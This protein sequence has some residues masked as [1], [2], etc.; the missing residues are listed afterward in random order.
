MEPQLNITENSTNLL[1]KILGKNVTILRNEAN[2]AIQSDYELEAKFEWFNRIKSNFTDKLRSLWNLAET[3]YSV[4]TEIKEFAN[5]ISNLWTT[6]NQQVCKQYSKIQIMSHTLPGIPLS[7]LLDKIRKEAVMVKMKLQ[8]NEV[9]YDFTDILR[10]YKLFSEIAEL[11][12][13]LERYDNKVQQYLIVSK[14]VPYLLKLESTIDKFVSS[15]TLLPKHQLVASD[16]H[17][18]SSVS[19]LLT[20]ELTGDE[21]INPHYVLAEN[22]VKKPVFIIKANKPKSHVPLLSTVKLLKNVTYSLQS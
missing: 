8:I 22:I 2:Y 6:M 19:K 3:H 16:L 18:F 12:N 20:G 9:T 5:H 10:G 15:T 21:I 13:N 17:V 11:L 7:S 14:L 1:L 4:N